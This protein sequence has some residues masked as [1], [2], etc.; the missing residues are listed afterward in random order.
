[1]NTQ[2]LR[3]PLRFAISLLV[4]LALFSMAVLGVAGDTA[5]PLTSLGGAPVGG[6]ISGSAA[7]SFDLYRVSYPGS[8]TEVRIQVTFAGH[9][10]ALRE[11]LGFSVYGYNGFEGQGIDQGD[12]LLELVYSAAEPTTLVVQ[13]FNY[14]DGLT[15][16]YSVVVKGMPATEAAPTAPLTVAQTETATVSSQTEWSGTLVGNAAGAFA[17][18]AVQS[19]G[20][21]VDAMVK[22]VFWPDDPIIAAAVGFGVYDSDGDLV[23]SGAATGNLG[24]RLATI[25]LSDVELLHVQIYNYAEGVTLGYIL[26]IAR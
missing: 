13:V 18:A 20:S 14:Y 7:G 2:M 12:D 19:D 11:G 21:G 15:L 5:T 24:E 6:V 8:E 26:S 25:A 17:Q 23:A 16:P 3:K 4:T 1:M 10:A 9:D 22:L